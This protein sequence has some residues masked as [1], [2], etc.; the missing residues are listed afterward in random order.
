MKRID[1]QKRPLIPAIQVINDVTQV[2]LRHGYIGESF[3]TETLKLHYQATF[4]IPEQGVV[5]LN[6]T[7]RPKSEATAAYVALMGFRS[8]SE[9]AR[10][11]K[12]DIRELSKRYNKIYSPLS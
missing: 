10:R 1:L 9:L 7:N 8:E 11:L 5:Y 4:E 2:C 3:L 12:N 6:A